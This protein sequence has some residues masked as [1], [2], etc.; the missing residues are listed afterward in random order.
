MSEF[1]ARHEPDAI[2]EAINKVCDAVDLP[3]DPAITTASQRMLDNVQ[4]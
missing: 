2:T 3:S 1:V 4:W